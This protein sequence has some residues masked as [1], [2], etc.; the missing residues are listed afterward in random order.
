MASTKYTSLALVKGYL[1]R[2]YSPTDLPDTS[3]TTYESIQTKI[4]NVSRS[5]DTMLGG[6]YVSFN[7]TDHSTYPTPGVIVQ[8]ATQWVVAL[9][10]RQLVPGDGN[11]PLGDRAASAMQEAKD[12]IS[13]IISEENS[14][15]IDSEV[16][17]SE[18]L[19]FGLGGQYALL[20][21]QAFINV[22]AKSP[23]LSRIASASQI[24]PIPPTITSGTLTLRST[25]STRSGYLPITS[26]SSARTPGRSPSHTSGITAAPLSIRRLSAQR[27]LA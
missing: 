21:T 11:S 23:R 16:V 4:L 14:Q 7:S 12:I 27:R 10:L 24:R 8:A 20:T 19:V 2:S 3:D 17:S 15:A 5:I 22:Q 9:S 13:A 1:P 26:A 18:T 25:P 6:R